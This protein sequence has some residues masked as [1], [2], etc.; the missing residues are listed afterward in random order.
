MKHFLNV[1]HGKDEAELS[2]EE[3]VRV[4]QIALAAKRSAAV[5][6]RMEE[7]LS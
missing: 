6:S 1:V 3:G 7:L 2:L 4:L 5:L